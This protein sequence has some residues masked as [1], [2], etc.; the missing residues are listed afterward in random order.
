MAKTIKV[1]KILDSETLLI[2]AG[3]NQKVN[4][5]DL[6]EIYETGELII[7]PDTKEQLGTLDYIKARV[8]ATMV[9]PNFS[10]VQSIEY[11]TETI[12]SGIM[13]AFTDKS[14]EVTK[15]RVKRIKV[16]PTQITPMKITNRDIIIGDFAKKI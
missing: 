1:L 6:F 3:S 8:E 10:L 15:S 5:G 2:S 14:K 13:N 7:D 16:D 12:T 4:E 9:Y 11:Y